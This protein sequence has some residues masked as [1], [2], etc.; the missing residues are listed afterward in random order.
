MHRDDTVSKDLLV[1]DVGNQL[2]IV[3]KR[4]TDR[5]I[6]RSTDEMELLM[7]VENLSEPRHHSV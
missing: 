4:E 1:K 7:E 3:N 2:Q 6:N 5:L